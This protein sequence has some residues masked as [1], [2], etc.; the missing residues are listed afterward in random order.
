MRASL[1]TAAPSRSAIWTRSTAEATVRGA[2]A[3]AAAG[4]GGL[5]FGRFEK[6]ATGL[7]VLGL[8]EEAFAIAN[9]FKR[10]GSSERHGLVLVKAV[11]A[12]LGGFVCQT[13]KKSIL[14]LV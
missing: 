4:A 5:I 9:E 8:G 6:A 13:E 10:S 11:L 14:Q 3:A 12:C 7:G 1:D 2:A